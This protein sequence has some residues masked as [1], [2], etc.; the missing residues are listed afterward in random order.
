MS[1]PASAA[2][3]ADA[4]TD[5]ELLSII[6]CVYPR[7]GRL[8]LNMNDYPYW[9]QLILYYVLDCALRFMCPWLPLKLQA[10]VVFP[11]SFLPSPVHYFVYWWCVLPKVAQ[12]I[13]K[14]PLVLPF[15]LGCW[16][17]HMDVV[18]QTEDGNFWDFSRS[19]DKGVTCKRHK[20]ERSLTAMLK[21]KMSK[22]TKIEPAITLQVLV[23]LTEQEKKVWYFIWGNNCQNHTF[24]ICK[25]LRATNSKTFK[26]FYLK[27]RCD[28][29][30]KLENPLPPQTT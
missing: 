16:A 6:V 5:D 23:N 22:A 12:A 30:Y 10:W 26:A 21:F 25:L 14:L 8:V 4:P 19:F 9:L 1:K 3:D 24:K 29:R 11:G 27:M 2:K 7:V 15:D 13:L 17:V 18:V 28:L 20:E